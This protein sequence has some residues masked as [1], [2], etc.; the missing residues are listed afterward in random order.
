METATVKRISEYTGL[1]FNEALQL[2]YSLF[3]LLG[4]ES[5]IYSYNQHSETREIL[6]NLWRLQQTE[7]DTG[8][9]RDFQNR[10]EG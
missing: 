6:K 3:L 5:W 8:A 2:P 4:K 9:I 7:A 10:R 1:N